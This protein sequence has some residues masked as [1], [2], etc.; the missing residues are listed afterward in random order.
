MHD[1][2]DWRREFFV[3][4]FRVLAS[5]PEIDSPCWFIKFWSPNTPA[6]HGGEGRKFWIKIWIKGVKRA[7]GM[8]RFCVLCNIETISASWVT[9]R[10]SRQLGCQ[11]VIEGSAS[12]EQE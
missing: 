1:F 12:V 7:V 4:G 10:T 8:C 6:Y 3:L 5:C 2:C 9:L 11:E